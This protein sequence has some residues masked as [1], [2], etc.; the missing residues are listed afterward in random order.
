M[1][2]PFGTLLQSPFLVFRLTPDKYVI[3]LLNE[4]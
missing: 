3:V 1:L 2:W 4:L